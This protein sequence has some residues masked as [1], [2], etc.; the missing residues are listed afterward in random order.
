MINA[1]QAKEMAM[2]ARCPR[3]INGI[4]FE[5]LIER[6]NSKIL[7][8][9]NKG[10]WNVKYLFDDMDYYAWSE[11]AGDYY[12]RKGLGYHTFRLNGVCYL[13]W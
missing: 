6:Q 2:E 13:A 3:E 8:A 9:V 12:L 11:K 10:A 1:K 7:E 5:E 4:T